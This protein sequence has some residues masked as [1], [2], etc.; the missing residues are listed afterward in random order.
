MFQIGGQAGLRAQAIIRLGLGQGRC[1]HD[2]LS[3]KKSLT[4]RLWGSFSPSPTVEEL[5]G[6]L[7][8]CLGNNFLE[9][10]EECG[11]KSLDLTLC[12]EKPTL[13]ETFS[14]FQPNI[15]LEPREISCMNILLLAPISP[16]V[17]EPP[18]SY[19]RAAHWLTLRLDANQS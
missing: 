4:T 10:V 9:L 15:D 16:S 11:C 6:S 7:L 1:H 12:N 19:R 14:C 3:A 2:Q 17:P 5:V 13:N 8:G 18:L